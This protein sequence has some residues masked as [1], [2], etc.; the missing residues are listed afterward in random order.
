MRREFK[1][2]LFLAGAMFILAVFIFI[3]GDLSVLFKKQGYDLYV[4]F[5]SAAGLE[6]R[7]VVRIA[8]VKAGYVKDIG[9]VAN[10][11]QVLMSIDPGVKIPLGSKATLAALGLLGEKYVEI[12]PAKSSQYYR[13]G[14]IMEGLP[15]VSFDQMGTLLLSIGDEVKAMGE[16]VRGLIGGKEARLHFRETIRNL[17]LLSN[18]L[19]QIVGA[20][21]KDIN[22][23]L[24][25]SSRAFQKFEQSV[26]EVSGNLDELVSLLKSTVE[27]NK[28]SIKV[29]L[30]KIRGLI[31]QTEETLRRLN[32]SLE[33]INRGEGSMGKLINDPQL[34]DKTQA[35]VEQMQRLVRPISGH[36]FSWGVRAAYYG[37]SQLLKTIMTLR[38]WSGSD[39]FLL[40]QAVRDP[41][42]NRFSYSLQAGWHWQSFSPRVGIMESK[43]GI[44]FDY[45]LLQDRL[46]F[47]LEGYDF[48]RHPRPHLRLWT[49]YSVTKYIYLLLG[50]DDFSLVPQ[51]EVFFGFGLGLT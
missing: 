7:A 47:S 10:Q 24:Q 27:E 50:I 9:L 39:K 33:K 21:R 34:Y 38:L 23:S 51:R 30:Q 19:R 40:A 29:N 46:R 36:H 31:D 3:V 6:K 4:K 20:N 16:E 15:A 13:P 14:E 18:D 42:L 48:N 37:Q 5:D 2:G 28:E 35:T 32:E 43:A 17:A 22:R 25:T 11:A 26:D 12:I 1:I 45:Y 49:Q 44:G 8:G 41:W